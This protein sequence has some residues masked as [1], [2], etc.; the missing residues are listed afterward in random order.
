M[1]ELAHVPS[2][3]F[4]IPLQR[5]MPPITAFLTQSYV[6]VRPQAIWLTPGTSGLFSILEKNQ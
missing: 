1:C 2:L 4:L 6:T 5:E 3:T